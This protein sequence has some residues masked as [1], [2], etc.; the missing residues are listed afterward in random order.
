[1]GTTPRPTVPWCPEL[2]GRVIGVVPTPQR[3]ARPSTVSS[4]LAP[5]PRL[6]LPLV[7]LLLPLTPLGLL[8][9]L[10]LGTA[11]LAH[12]SS[13]TKRPARINVHSISEAH[14]HHSE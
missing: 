11:T 4:A 7:A 6:L 8:A 12:D 10:V 9:L 13:T 3:Y 1:M 14:H 2:T 5:G